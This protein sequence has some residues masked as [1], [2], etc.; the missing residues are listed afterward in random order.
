M[1]KKKIINTK[2]ASNI[3]KNKLNMLTTPLSYK[4]KRNIGLFYRYTDSLA[5]I[6]N[7]TA[8]GIRNGEGV[9]VRVSQDEAPWRGLTEYL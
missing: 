2:N 5:R 3:V 9:L 4:K 6:G 7:W 8:S 1:I